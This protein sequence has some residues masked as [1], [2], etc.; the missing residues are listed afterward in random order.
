[1]KV[2]FAGS[3]GIT[4]YDIAPLVPEGTTLIISGGARGIDT[5]AERY[6]DAHGIPKQ[7]YYPDYDRYGR[8][9][10]IRRNEVMVD[11]ADKVIVIWDGVSRG[12]KFTIDYAKR[13]GKEV[14]V[15]IV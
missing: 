7:I 10:P 3:R 11:L 13:K 6:A 14:T 2:L 12:S 5:I 4:N 15:K 1:M 8:S 9:A